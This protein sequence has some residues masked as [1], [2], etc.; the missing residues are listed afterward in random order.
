MK[1]RSKIK[2]IPPAIIIHNYYGKGETDIVNKEGQDVNVKIKAPNTAEATFKDRHP[3]IASILTVELG[4][5]FLAFFC[6]MYVYSYKASY[7]SYYGIPAF[8]TEVTIAELLNSSWLIVNLLQMLLAALYGVTCFWLFRAI[9]TARI[10]KGAWISHLIVQMLNLS[11]FLY[12]YLVLYEISNET[13]YVP[14]EIHKSGEVTLADM[15][16]DLNINKHIY[17]IPVFIILLCIYS[18]FRKYKRQDDESVEDGEFYKRDDRLYSYKIFTLIG[19]CITVFFTIVY[20]YTSSSTLGYDYAKTKAVYPFLTR[21]GKVTNEFV[22]GMYKEN[23]IV[24]ELVHNRTD[25]SAQE[26]DRPKF[27]KDNYRL[28]QMDEENLT[29]TQLKVYGGIHRKE[30]ADFKST[31][32]SL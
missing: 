32:E 3:I 15:I 26:L 1:R 30:K 27:I 14:F 19:L 11:L 5:G 18:G 2:K 13:F 9:R 16:V 10:F 21:E 25:L 24:V 22:I 12:F 28:V 20:C 29:F 8:Y 7:L 23:Y 17:F 6:Y 31:D 4:L